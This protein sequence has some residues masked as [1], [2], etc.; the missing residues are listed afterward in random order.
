MERHLAQTEILV[1]VLSSDSLEPRLCIL[2][3]LVDSLLEDRPL[4]PGVICII[5]AHCSDYL[6]TSV[7]FTQEE[8][9]KDPES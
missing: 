2:H 8:K 7:P 3:Y 6:V 5:H 4:A 1:V 9:V